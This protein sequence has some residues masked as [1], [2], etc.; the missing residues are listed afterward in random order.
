MLFLLSPE[1]GEG[2]G[3]GTQLA[4]QRVGKESSRHR[5]CLRDGPKI[6]ACLTLGREYWGVEGRL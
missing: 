5:K 1:G 2:A 4:L 3:L 6:R